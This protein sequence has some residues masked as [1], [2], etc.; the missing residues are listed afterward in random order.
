MESYQIKPQGF[1]QK[2]YSI[3]TSV[4]LKK[5]KKKK[6]FSRSRNSMKS[7]ISNLHTHENESFSWQ[8]RSNIVG[9]WLLGGQS[10]SF[11]NKYKALKKSIL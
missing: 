7:Q 9:V 2:P 4:R 3:F 1:K 11:P 5:K 6:W 8:G 10:Y